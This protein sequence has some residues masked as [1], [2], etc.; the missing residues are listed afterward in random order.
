MAVDWQMIQPPQQLVQS[1]YT[2][3]W[4]R[5]TRATDGINRC[6]SQTCSS[7]CHEVN[8][9]DGAVSDIDELLCIRDLFMLASC[10]WV[11]SEYDRRIQQLMLPYAGICVP[12][13][14]YL[15]LWRGVAADPATCWSSGQ[16]PE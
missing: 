8:H 10:L 4:Q 3:N 2:Q 13:G 16:G 5:P 14:R 12:A 11:P 6:S 9:A 15:R 7:V 1:H